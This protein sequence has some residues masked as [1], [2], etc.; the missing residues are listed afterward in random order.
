MVAWVV[1][2]YVEE[3][4]FNVEDALGTKRPTRV[5]VGVK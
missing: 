4:R 3:R 1:V 5:E 2:P